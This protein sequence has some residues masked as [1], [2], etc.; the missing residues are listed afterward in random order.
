M[1]ATDWKAMG[2]AML[3]AAIVA[4]AGCGDSGSSSQSPQIP[5]AIA[6]RLAAL[7]DRT[8]DDLDAGD[9]CG[10]AASVAQLKQEA[11]DAQPEVPDAL[12]PELQAGVEQLASQI[13]CV[14][15]PAPLPEPTP[16]PEKVPKPEP[17]P[18][19]TGCSPGHD[20]TDEHGHG[21]KGHGKDEQGHDEQKCDTAAG[22]GSGEEGG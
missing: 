14:P 4:I 16:K 1:R 19:E 13:E 15:E 3:L 5:A 17:K 2:A 9:D 20:K 10:A 7:S 22:G 18:E 12:R 21:E 11:E 8:A 6:G